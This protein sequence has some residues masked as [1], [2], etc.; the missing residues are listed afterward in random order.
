MND[1]KRNSRNNL[2][3][4]LAEEHEKKTKRMLLDLQIFFETHKETLKDEDT[5]RLFSKTLLDI[6]VIEKNEATNKISMYELL[7]LLASNGLN[8]DILDISNKEK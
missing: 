2:M 3:D 7:I 8:M 5:Y 1:K 4:I 6:P